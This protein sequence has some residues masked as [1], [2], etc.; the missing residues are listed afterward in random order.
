MRLLKI[1][2]NDSAAASAGEVSSYE[3]TTG[4]SR[5]K[6]ERAESEE[7]ASDICRFRPA[8]R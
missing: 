4:A 7:Q 2:R 1:L 5:R 6:A 8:R 3:S